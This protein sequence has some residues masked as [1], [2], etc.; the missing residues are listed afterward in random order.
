MLVDIIRMN[1]RPFIT[2]FVA[3]SF[4]C[5]VVEL[6]PTL[7]DSNQEPINLNVEIPNTEVPMSTLSFE[8]QGGLHKLDTN[9]FSGYGVDYYPSGKLKSKTAFANGE[10]QGLAVVYFEDGHLKSQAFY[11]RN[12][13]H[14]EKKNWAG[15][16]HHHL[17]ASRTYQLGLAHGEHTKWYG[18]GQ[19]FKIMRYHMGKEKGLQQAFLENGTLY[20]NYEA[21]NGRSF[22]LKKSMLCFEVN[23][24]E[25]VK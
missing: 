16:A 23:E 19:V 12:K 1:Y 14:G 15:T 8:R 24:E 9:L 20:A 25:V 13:L 5:C 2:L 21:K 7:L 3:L 17:M 18:N 11:H 6:H 4:I 10:K 22:G